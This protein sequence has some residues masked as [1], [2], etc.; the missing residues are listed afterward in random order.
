[1][2]A[3]NS[4]RI[5]VCLGLLLFAAGCDRSPQPQPLTVF[6]S[7][8]T[9]GWITPC[10]CTSNQSGGL[11]RRDT[12]ITQAAA[13][14]PV[15]V[16]DVGGA[17]AN[18]SRYDWVKLQAILRGQQTMQ[19]DAFNL[20]G[21]ESH[22]AASDLKRLQSESKLPLISANLRDE[23][24]QSL[25]PPYRS[26]ERGGQTVA[27][28]GVIDPELVADPLTAGDPYQSIVSQLPRIT[29]DRVIVLAY[30]DQSKLKALAQKLP[31]VDAVIGGPTGQVVPPAMVGHVLVSSS[32]NKGKFLLQ[33]KL[34]PGHQVDAQVVEVS[35]EIA[36][37][38]RQEENVQA[39]YATLGRHDFAPTDT[40]F[41]ARRIVTTDQPTIAGNETCR[42]CHQVDDALW[43]KSKHSHAWSSLQL[44]GAQVD[45]ACQRCHTTGYGIQ[46]GFVNIATSESRQNVGC[47]NCH[48]PSAN[49]VADPRIKTPFVAKEQCIS[50]HD[51]EN[52]PE[53]NYDIYWSKILHGKDPSAPLIQTAAD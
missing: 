31:D 27:V 8:D 7:G 2:S 52:S 47:E 28:I 41:V 50:C 9:A 49:H 19:L 3:F 43:H 14:G 5:I 21:P 45:P 15:L 23:S 40:H 17:V 44:T 10:G 16:L 30:M 32:T 22:F 36:L 53:F 34:R 4:S 37:S 1:M 13:R 11:S 20:G 48:G 42:S 35:S 26:I 25:A 46:D 18:H 24:G 51:H 12:L 33:M 39:F 29:A 38:E 6:I